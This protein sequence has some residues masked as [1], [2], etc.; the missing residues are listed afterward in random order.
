MYLVP[1]AV[2]V[3]IHVHCDHR[4]SNS[5]SAVLESAT[6]LELVRLANIDPL[7][8]LSGDQVQQLEVEITNLTRSMSSCHDDSMRAVSLCR[9]GA[10]LRKVCTCTF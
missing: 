6:T 1:V 9:R 7:S 2:N 10:L 3:C 8:S 4:E 5:S